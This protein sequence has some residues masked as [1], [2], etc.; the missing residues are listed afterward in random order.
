M[1]KLAF[2]LEEKQQSRKALLKWFISFTRPGVVRT[3]IH[4]KRFTPEELEK[5]YKES[6]PE[7]PLGR[8]VDAS[9]V[10]EAILYL[11]SDKAS[12]VTGM[13]LSVDGGISL[14]CWIGAVNVVVD[15]SQGVD[16]VLESLAELFR[17]VAATSNGHEFWPGMSSPNPDTSVSE[18]FAIS[19]KLTPCLC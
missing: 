11:A 8:A 15:R 4:S 7:A 1:I 17:N 2:C 3:K 6:G 14:N 12:S 18:S 10:A 5:Y 9:E 19:F 13:S 16:I